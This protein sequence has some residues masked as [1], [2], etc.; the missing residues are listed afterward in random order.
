MQTSS[1]QS[2]QRGLAVLECVNRR[3]GA[4]INEIAGMVG[5]ARGTTYRVLET[6][7]R[8]GYLVKPEPRGPYWL[9]SRVSG[10]SDGYQAEAW[11]EA[12]KPIVEEL[13]RRFLWP[14]TVATPDGIEMNLR[15][16][17]DYMSP[18][19]KRRF[20]AG[21]RRALWEASTGRV[22]LAFCSE[23]QQETLIS[24]IAASVGA[25]SRDVG[26]D[27]QALARLIAPIK[28]LGYAFYEHDHSV[29]QLAVP[30]FVRKQ[31]FGAIAIRYFS[32]VVSRAAA[33]EKFL[34]SLR[35]AAGEICELA[36]S[37][38]AVSS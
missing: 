4:S 21:H 12:I 31:V 26:K 32:S 14:V 1:I 36:G 8:E 34:P 37:A 6:L 20:S 13:S 38:V 5:L 18:L 15:A 2:L 10:L 30:I 11:V 28:K 23:E 25:K 24:L 27:G 7:R 35:K 19:V 3:N 22:Y 29:T 9:A 33:L 17:T 16:T